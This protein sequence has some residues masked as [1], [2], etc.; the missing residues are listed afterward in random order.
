MERSPSYAQRR[1]GTSRVRLSV[2][3]L[4]VASLLEMGIL[5]PHTFLHRAL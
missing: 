3:V 5:I 4:T 1:S 2:S